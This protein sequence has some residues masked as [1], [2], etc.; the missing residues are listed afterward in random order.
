MSSQRNRTITLC[1]ENVKRGL[2]LLA[3]PDCTYQKHNSEHVIIMA[4]TRALS[5]AILVFLLVCTVATAGADEWEPV[6]QPPTETYSGKAAGP[7]PDLELQRRGDTYF[8]REISVLGLRPPLFLSARLDRRLAA[9]TPSALAD[10]MRAAVWALA[11]VGARDELFVRPSVNGG[12]PDW[13]P[14]YYG[15]FPD[16]YPYVLYGTVSVA[17]SQFDDLR[18]LRGAF[19]VEYGDALSGVIVVE[20]RHVYS[21]TQTAGFS[22]DLLRSRLHVAGPLREWSYAFSFETSFYDKVLSVVSRDGYPHSSSVLSTLSR[23]YGSRQVSLRTFYATGG[24]DARIEPTQ[25]RYTTASTATRSGKQR[26]ELSVQQTRARA[27]HNTSVAYFSDGEAYSAVDGLMGRNAGALNEFL[28]D[29]TLGA[30]SY[31][32]A[33]KSTLFLSRGHALDVG[34]TARRD[35]VSQCVQSEGWNFAPIFNPGRDDVSDTTLAGTDE[36]LG[37]WRFAAYAQ[38]RRLIRGCRVSLGARCDLLNTTA[39]PA[40]RFSAERPF[41]GVNVRVAG[42]QYSRFPV[43]GTF[44][45][46]RLSGLVDTYTRPESALHGLLGLDVNLHP[47]KLSVEFHRQTYHDLVIRDDYGTEYRDGTGYLRCAD[48]TLSTPT[49]NEKFWAYATASFGTAEVMEVPTDWDQQIQA[50]TVCFT[51]LTR[52]LELTTRTFFGSGLAFTPLMGRVPLLDS[53]QQVVTDASGSVVYKAVW[54]Q[55]NSARLP[56]QFR[57]DLRLAMNCELFGEKAKFYVEALNVTDHANVSGMDYLDYYSRS[58]FRTNLPRAAN[59]GFELLF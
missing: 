24:A 59:L 22:V 1:A 56:A 46:G 41:G 5:L 14:V 11:G 58:V 3:L 4:K 49:E 6:P 19:P 33:H 30:R 20:P 8:M 34:A 28:A 18:V 35:E 26:Y 55:G 16:C 50:K 17:N 43:G 31:G 15:S 21:R 23:K 45:E 57:L 32:L 39:V 9:G 42:G 12:L 2:M 53:S 52:T 51:R 48:I 38:E 44:R 7:P 10:P 37:Y 36:R 47:I 25:D 54:G 27:I 29:V 13:V 40:L